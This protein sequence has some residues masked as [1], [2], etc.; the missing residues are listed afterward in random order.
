MKT[1]ESSIKNKNNVE[2]YSDNLLKNKRLRRNIK[3]IESK[4]YEV[5]D[6][7][8]IDLIKIEKNNKKSLINNKLEEKNHIK[9]RLNFEEINEKSD[10]EGIKNDLVNK[11][12]KTSDISLKKI[13]TRRNT[14]D[15][16]LKDLENMMTSKKSI[17][18]EITSNFDMIKKSPNLSI[19]K[20]F[21]SNN[22]T[23]IKNHKVDTIKL[24]NK[25]NKEKTNESHIRNLRKKKQMKENYFNK[26]VDSISLR[27]SRS[28]S[29]SSESRSSS[30]NSSEK[31]DNYC[32]KQTRYSPRL[33]T[34]ISNQKNKQIILKKTTTKLTKSSNR[35]L[36]S[37]EKIDFDTKSLKFETPEK[38]KIT[39]KNSSLSGI[40]TY[41]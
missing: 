32:Q 15:V 10:G 31:F 28:V 19:K 38:T 35:E 16:D 33:E 11:K 36:K 18:K 17:S 12:I 37:L 14:K 24:I 30:I 4:H 21:G 40:L 22:V 27:K 6:K 20:R 34:K 9:K 2:I 39:S 7:K 5:K 1:K 3:L 25:N 13:S 8:D 41:L 29:S 23:P 26:I